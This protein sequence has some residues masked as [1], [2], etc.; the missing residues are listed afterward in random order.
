MLE[1]RF[2]VVSRTGMTTQS[3]IEIERREERTPTTL[4]AV[5]V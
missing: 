3:P 4:N 5:S 1:H 2:E